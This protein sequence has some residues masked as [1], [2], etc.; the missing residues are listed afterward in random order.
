MTAEEVIAEVLSSVKTGRM[1][2]EE[3]LCRLIAAG[4]PPGDAETRIRLLLL[5]EQITSPFR[6]R[7]E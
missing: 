7:R 1:D 5:R 3:A 6:S 4:L 2:A